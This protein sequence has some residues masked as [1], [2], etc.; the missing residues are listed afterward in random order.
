VS[1]Q[2]PLDPLE[3]ALARIHTVRARWTRT[4]S[5]D[6]MRRDW[7]ALFASEVVP[8]E[9]TRIVADGVEGELIR[10]ADAREGRVVLYL[11]GGGFSSG[12][13]RSHHDLAA[14][15][16]VASHSPVFLLE[17]RRV[18]EHRFPA[19]V[20]DSL[21]AARW[22][23]SAGYAAD[24]GIVLGGDSAGGTLAMATLL[25]LRDAGDV[26]PRAAVLLSPWLDLTAS[27]PS[28][29]THAKLDPLHRRSV[30]LA[31]AKAYLGDADPRHPWASPV[32]ADLRGL[33]PLLVQVGEREII[34]DDSRE[35]AA[36][37]TAS[38]VPV[39]L[40]VWPGMVHV[41]QQLAELPEAA[42]AIEG[43][44]AFIERSWA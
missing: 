11:H 30:L 4:T 31:I 32:F 3:R 26:S 8:V 10:S 36:R 17:Y 42:R 9:T 16:A 35:L 33:P 44:G 24:G 28:Y 5:V 12:S 15:I 22:L 27:L 37:A 19:P 20:E 6:E 18:P 40:E 1:T 43:I 41:F 39:Q 13:A 14:R 34:V 7:D 25:A 23:R 29:E 2:E 38:G 21:R